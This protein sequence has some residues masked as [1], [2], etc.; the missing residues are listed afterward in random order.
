MASW[1]LLL[2]FTSSVVLVACENQCGPDKYET[3]GTCCQ[4][5]PP[6]HYVSKP[7]RK[8]PRDGECA[9]CPPD[10]F[11]AHPSPFRYCQHCTQCGKRQEMVAD[12][13]ATSDRKCQC[14]AGYFC[15]QEHCEDCDTCSSCLRGHTPIQ[16][17]NAT[18]DTVCSLDTDTAVAVF[19]PVAVPLLLLWICFSCCYYCKRREM[20]RE[21]EGPASDNSSCQSQEA[22]L[23]QDKGGIPAAP[24]VEPT[25]Q[26]KISSGFEPENRPPRDLSEE[27]G[28]GTELQEVLTEGGLEVPEPD[29]AA[30]DRPQGHP[31]AMV[32]IEDLEEIQRRVF[33][34][35]FHPGRHQ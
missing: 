8:D 31:K 16:P 13:N 11:R 22:L 2:L 3:E 28:Q 23:S 35:G 34:E 29:P 19:L 12:C 33:P 20:P 6:G 30:V 4:K 25:L 17:C 1:A 9:V 18:S 14:A 24:D 21:T 5:C 32:G 7:C 15:A 10:T 26:E 27:P